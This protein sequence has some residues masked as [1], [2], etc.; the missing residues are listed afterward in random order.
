MDYVDISKTILAGC[1]SNN[2]WYSSYMRSNDP[3]IIAD[4]KF[5][6]RHVPKVSTIL[7]IGGVP[8]LFLGYLLSYGFESCALAD[9]NPEPFIQYLDDSKISYSKEDLLNNLPVELKNKFDLVCLNEVVEHIGGNL[10]S[11]ISNA[12]GCVKPGGMIMVTTPNL[13]SVWGLYSLLVKKSGL[14][15]KPNDTVRAQYDRESAA[16]GYF[17]HIREYT[18]KEIVDLLE[19]FGLKLLHCEF[20]KDYRYHGKATT[21]IN[22]IESVFPSW[23][24]FGK[25][26]FVKD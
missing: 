18:Q 14:A 23:R 21:I 4:A 2:E 10:L 13:R 22:L 24:L 25:Y 16:Y 6:A 19:S 3:R 8:P 20:Q 26:L 12:I 7:D 9:P 5:V 15:A 11:A 17:G 1:T